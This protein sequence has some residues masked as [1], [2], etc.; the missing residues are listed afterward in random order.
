M[1]NDVSDADSL[2]LRTPRFGVGLG[3][4]KVVPT[5]Y[6][7]RTLKTWANVWTNR[8]DE[9]KHCSRYKDM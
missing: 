4:L 7:W 8:K 1:Y 3:G 2:R 5:P 9:I 6:A